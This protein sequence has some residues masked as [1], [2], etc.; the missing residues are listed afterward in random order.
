MTSIRRRTA[1]LVAL[2]MAVLLVVG[3]VV[4]LVVLRRAMTAQFDDAL[5][6]RAAALQSLTRFDGTKVEMDFAG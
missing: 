1:M 4:L 5:V 2:S 6:A 3:G